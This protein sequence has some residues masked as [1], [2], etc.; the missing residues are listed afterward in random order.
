MT[1]EPYIVVFID[2]LGF[3][4]MVDKSESEDSSKFNT[5]LE[6]LNKFKSIENP[7]TWNK[8]NFLVEI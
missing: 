4:D 3:K 1:Y 2:I 7:E 5:I 6:I 8:A